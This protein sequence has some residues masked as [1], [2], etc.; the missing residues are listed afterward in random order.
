MFKVEAILNIV[1]LD[2]DFN[3]YGR[4]VDLPALVER[5]IMPIVRPIAGK[6]E[7]LHD[8]E[9]VTQILLSLA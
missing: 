5:G 4:E 1:L 7:R 2:S 8:A 9:A 3:R 6:D